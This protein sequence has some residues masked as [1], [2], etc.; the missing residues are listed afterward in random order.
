ME[1]S[2][3]QPKELKGISRRNILIAVLIGLGVS[4]FLIARSFD[5]QAFRQ[6]EWTSTVFL[7]MALALTMMI[8]RHLA[9]M[10]RVWLVTGKVLSLRQAFEVIMMWEFASAVTPS[11]VGGA[12]VAM[13]IVNREGINM[14]K[15]TASV[16]IITMMDNLFFVVASGV[17]LLAIGF[18]DMFALNSTCAGELNM[19]FLKALGGLQYVFLLGFS[20]SAVVVLL[21]FYG[22]L[23]NP[24]GVRKMLVAFTYIKWLKKLRHKAFQTGDDLITT[25]RE[26]RRKSA[27]FWIQLFLVTAFAWS[28]KYLVVNSVLTA[29]GHI[30]GHEQIII[31]S[32][33]LALWVVMLIPFTPG[34]SGLAEFTFL[35][36]MCPFIQPI[37]LSGAVTLLWRSFTYYPYLLL[38]TIVM[39]R[40]LRRISAKN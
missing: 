24:R 9:Y 18:T 27:W 17:A 21:L 1:N 12:A 22:A 36:L 38:G 26:L 37:E 25:A 39:P 3:S 40:W 23:V 6:I 4:A 33:V 7:F 8:M 2:S 15:S 16:M 5:V 30:T 34:A 32:R 10:Y 11:T 31:M 35:A 13:F 28:L 29:F 14:G 19:P 20:F